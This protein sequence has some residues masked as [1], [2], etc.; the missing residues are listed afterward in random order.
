[1]S[2]F[3]SWE[4]STITDKFISQLGSIPVPLHLN[5]SDF[6]GWGILSLAVGHATRTNFP[7]RSNCTSADSFNNLLQKF[8]KY[9][10]ICRFLCYNE[11]VDIQ[12]HGKSQPDVLARA[13]A[14]SGYPLK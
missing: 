3:L 6:G 1:M 2:A 12:I 8:L 5:A 4:L 13:K 10:I 9:A 11:T 14:G 7:I